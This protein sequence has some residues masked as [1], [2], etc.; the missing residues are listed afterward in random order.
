MAS[1]GQLSSSTSS[2]SARASVSLGPNDLYAVLGCAADSSN[3]RTLN[4]ANTVSS[5]MTN[6]AC[7]R[8]C[9]AQGFDRAGTEYYSE[10]YCGMAPVNWN[11]SSQCTTPCA[12]N[13]SQTCGGPDALTLMQVNLEFE[14]ISDATPLGYVG[15]FN[16]G[17][18]P[19]LLSDAFFAS[20][21]MTNKLCGNY[22]SGIGLPYAG[23]AY[24]GNCYCGARPNAT[25]TMAGNCYQKCYGNS[26]EFCGGNGVL[27]IYKN[28]LTNTTLARPDLS[29][30][31]S[32]VTVSNVFQPISNSA[33]L[34]VFPRTSHPRVPQNYTG[35]TPIQTNK[36]WQQ[37]LINGQES[38]N[39]VI[40]YVFNYLSPASFA[41]QNANPSQYEYDA[42][43][44]PPVF[45]GT[46]LLLKQLV[47]TA[48]EFTSEDSEPSLD[49]S[50]GRQ[51]SVRV[52][53]SMPG[54]TPQTMTTDLVSGM[55]FI[56]VHYASLTPAIQGTF[57]NFAAV[58]LT[59]YKPAVLQ[60]FRLDTPDSSWLMYV[61][62]TGSAGPIWSSNG[63][64]ISAAGAYTGTIQFAKLSVLSSSDAAEQVLDQ[65]AGS[66]VTGMSLAGGVSGSSGT[67]SLVYT[68]DSASGTPRSTALVYALPHHQ[69]F[70]SGS[71]KATTLYMQSP[72]TGAARAYVASTLTMTD[73]DLPA[74]VG[75]FPPD[76]GA[77]WNQ[78]TLLTIKK[79]LTPDILGANYTTGCNVYSTYFSGKCMAKAAQVCLVARDVIRDPVLA[80]NCIDQLE[81]VMNVFVANA[82]QLGLSYDTTWGGV[83]TEAGLSNLD[84]DFGN[85]AYN[86]HHFHYGYII[87]AA[88]ALAEL[89][90]AWLRRGNNMAWVDTLVRDVATPNPDD[91]YF[92]Q[93]RSMDWYVGHSLSHGVGSDFSQGKD[94]ESSSEDYNFAYGLKLWGHV[95]GR[96]ALEG[97]GLLMTG[98]IRRSVQAYML[99]GPDNNIQPA[100][101]TP[102]Y[103]SGI[104]FGGALI[105]STFFGGQ[106]QFVHGIHMLPMTGITSFVRTPRFVGMEWNNVLS[107]LAGTLTDN[108]AGILYSNL[109]VASAQASW[110]FFSAG[111]VVNF[112][113]AF[114]DDGQTLTWTLLF[115]AAFGGRA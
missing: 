89:R 56:T 77:T 78:Q 75:F 13:S 18:K 57:S 32:S 66:W 36:Q 8:F 34:D 25:A 62:D 12:G 27:S 53:I 2:A 87:Y 81:G 76:D 38:A 71:A 60:K 59:A 22:C 96:P 20:S 1:S 74:S 50:E 43:Q 93:F 85:A 3:T 28:A 48:L 95:T 79:S 55:G 29:A 51:A 110:D 63:T 45:Y 49:V 42:S 31:I 4:K 73:P 88:A 90:P 33:P 54:S 100:V 65:T 17:T 68:V 69:P 83:L 114:L 16:L 64:L 112:N 58:P 107:K 26:S 46:P 44:A 98:V 108:W 19:M 82:Q 101:Y 52:K 37:I 61:L 99:L 7:A 104:T 97:L 35:N 80:T 106:T 115:A 9:Y 113:R 24:G 21:S 11:V 111:N 40:P 102:N 41:W 15:C 86:D 103:V 109:A 72:I 92:P 47:T 67:Y 70:I 84:I 30:G 5:T 105:H 23:T 14:T 91:L 39:M 6:D 10:C 94:E